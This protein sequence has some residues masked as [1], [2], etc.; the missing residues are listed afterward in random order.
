MLKIYLLIYQ[1]II[2]YLFLPDTVQSMEVN[3]KYL[4]SLPQRNSQSTQSSDENQK[5]CFIPFTWIRAMRGTH[6]NS[7]ACHLPKGQDR[8]K[9]RQSARGV[10]KKF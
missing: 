7:E 6:G 9:G 3:K 5:L 2:E 1:K 8:R 10:I 4:Q